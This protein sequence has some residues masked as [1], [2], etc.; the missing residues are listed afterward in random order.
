MA[1][2]DLRQFLSNVLIGLCELLRVEDG[3]VLVQSDAGLQVEAN[4]GDAEAARRYAASAA[5]AERWERSRGRGAHRGNRPGIPGGYR[6]LVLSAAQ[7]GRRTKMLGLLALRAR[8]PKLI[9]TRMSRTR[10]RDCWRKRPSP[11]L[12]ATYSR[13]SLQ[14][15]NGC[16]RIRTHP[17]VAQRRSDLRRHC[18]RHRQL[19]R[20]NQRMQVLCWP[21]TRGSSG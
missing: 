9:W 1:S 5:A 10:S 3:F 19:Q 2:S 16:C 12:I 11:S 7:P 6:P 8:T 21:K 20:R 15:S 14:L 4:V 18:P 17:G 13:M